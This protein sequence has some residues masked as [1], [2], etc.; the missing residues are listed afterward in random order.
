MWKTFLQ[1]EVG[2]LL[3]QSTVHSASLDLNHK[4]KKKQKQWVNSDLILTLERLISFMGRVEIQ[5]VGFV[6]RLDTM[7][8]ERTWEGSLFLGTDFVYCL[9][10]TKKKVFVFVTHWEEGENKAARPDQQQI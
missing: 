3:S 1:S 4:I 8:W 7:W 2:Q 10:L 9:V 5:I 6:Q